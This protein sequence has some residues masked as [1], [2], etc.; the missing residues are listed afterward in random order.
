MTVQS[1]SVKRSPARERARKWTAT[2]AAAVSVLA[3]VVLGATPASAGPPAPVQ[4]SAN[5]MAPLEISDWAAFDSQ[6][7][8]VKEYGV[9]GVSVDVWWGKVE[10]S[11]NVFD[12][13]YYDQVFSH[14]TAKSLAVVPILSFHQCGGNVG[15]TCDIPLPSWLWSKYANK[16]ID[17]AT[18]GVDGLKYRSEQGNLSKETVQVWADSL[19][20][21]EYSDVAKAFKDHFA[22]QYTSVVPE[23]NISLGPSGELRYPSYNSQ[24][25]GAG[26]PSRGALQ[27]YSIL[28]VKSFRAFALQRYGTLAGVNN[29]WGTQLATAAQ[30]T[31]PSDAGS[32]FALGDYRGIPYGRDFVDW[33]NQSLVDHGKAMIGAVLG[34]LG[35]AFPG[36]NIGYKIPGVHWAMTN[37]A[38]PRAAEVAAGLI[39]TSVDLDADSTGHGYAKVIGLANAVNGGTHRLVL[40][41]TCLE[42]DNQESGPAYS[43]AKALVFWVAAEAKSLGVAI[44]GENALSGG[45]T[46]DAGWDNVE[47]AFTWSS[48]RG[49][50]ALRISEV[51]SGLGRQRYAAFI[52]KFRPASLLTIHY[53]E[54]FPAAGFSVHTWNGLEANLPMTFEGVFNGQRWWSATVTTPTAFSLGFFGAGAQTDLLE[55]KYLGV[56]GDIYLLPKD[57]HVYPT[58]PQDSRG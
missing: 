7:E 16:K 29:A 42:M 32:F 25:V 17:G 19:V 4:F 43:Q 39:Q 56:S 20:L 37:P 31:P 10:K 18:L 50:T 58:R 44:K 2:T 1:I 26:Y 9:N 49:F 57:A 8:S 48:Y 14:I 21:N 28:A 12:W 6:L 13:S 47:N 22:A 40:H 46:G 53:A 45:V 52:Q 30:I 27:S 38:Y 5:V 23:I 55:R 41:F 35:T 34:G 54:P 36:A 15:D 3:G 24:D 51:A 11:D 33:Y